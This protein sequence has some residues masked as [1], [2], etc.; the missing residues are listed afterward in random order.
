MS[1]QSIFYNIFARKQHQQKKGITIVINKEENVLF[2]F[3]LKHCK[4]LLRMVVCPDLGMER[5]Y[6]HPALSSNVVKTGVDSESAS[7]NHLS[8]RLTV[9]PVGPSGPVLTTL[10][11]STNI[12]IYILKL[13]STNGFETLCSPCSSPTNFID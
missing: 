13:K 12:Y 8:V 7:H 11:S 4:S 6:P 2:K 1:G 10:L 3:I 5:A 9:R